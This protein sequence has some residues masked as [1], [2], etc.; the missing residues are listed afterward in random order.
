MSNL[1]LNDQAPT[2][3]LSYYIDN[4]T[5]SG[6]S[7]TNFLNKNS[8]DSTIEEETKDFSEIFN[9]YSNNNKPDKTKVENRRYS[10]ISDSSVENSN[11]NEYNVFKNTPPFS[12][13]FNE[14]HKHE[15]ERNQ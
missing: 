5:F 9:K 10:I 3:A 7:T 13:K 1:L 6:Y 4:E 12:F 14:P 11:E 2:T 8:F 15:K